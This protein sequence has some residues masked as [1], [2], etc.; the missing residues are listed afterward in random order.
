M[1]KVEKFWKAWA[2]ICRV[3]DGSKPENKPIHGHAYLMEFAEAYGR[4]MYLKGVKDGSYDYSEQSWTDSDIRDLM[5]ELDEIEEN[6]HKAN[7]NA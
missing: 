4:Y 3:F 6:P 5:D 1:K 2:S 7:K